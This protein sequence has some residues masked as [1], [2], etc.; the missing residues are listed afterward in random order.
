[1]KRLLLLLPLLVS[2]LHA[3]QVAITI[4]DFPFRR[5]GLPANEEAEMVEKLYTYLDEFDIQA[6]GFINAKRIN[7]KNA[8]AIKE[9]LSRGH[10][11]ANHTYVHSNID[12]VGAERFILDIDKGWSEGK[13]FINSKYFRYPYLRRGNTLERRDSVYAHLEK[14]GYIIAHVSIDNNE[15]IYNRDYVK[16]RERGQQKEMDSIATAYLNHMKEVSLNYEKDA[17]TLTGSSIKHILL[18]HANPINAFYLGELL[19]WYKEQG[20]GFITLEEAL[21]DPIY[22]MEGDF[23]SPYGWSIIDKV[24]KMI[25]DRASEPD[26]K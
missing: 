1:M 23:V 26:G 24:K 21:T 6:T 13:E 2:S 12:Q 19:S 17:I 16:A 20:W 14:E 4:D 18:I 5:M 22:D 7:A 10:T 9:F 15:W 11:M 25:K 8:P 3:Q